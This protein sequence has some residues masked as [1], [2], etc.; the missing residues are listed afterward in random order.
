MA[1]KR[2]TKAQRTR[3]IYI[4]VAFVL[5]IAVIGITVLLVLLLGSSKTTI[6]LNE[7]THITLTGFNGEGVLS[8]SMDTDD[9]YTAFFETVDVEFSKSTNL[10]NGDEVTITY[11]YDKKV[12]KEYKIKVKVADMH[13]TVGNLVDAKPV[14]KNELFDGV[15][16]SFEGIAPMVEATLVT[17]KNEF[18]DIVSYEIIGGQQY[19][20]EGDT[21][22]VRAIFDEEELAEKDYV[23]EVT[24]EQCIKEYVVEDVD[25]YVTDI[26][27]ITDEM[28][29]SLKKEALSLFTDANEYG[30]RIFCDAGLVPVYIDKK[31]TFKW[32]SPNY[33]SSYLN[34]LKDESFG[35]TGTHVNDIK[36]CYE[37]VI[38]QADGKACKAEVVVRYEN[39]IVRADG[40]VDLNLES[41][42]IISAD[43]RD[44]HIKALVNNVIDDD[45]ES[46]KI[47]V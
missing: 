32:N 6:D 37:S 16:V 25:R 35:K 14:S 43:R 22:K 30:M 34:V 1:R 8:A 21:V 17:N 7:R 36:L 41:G 45:Y 10:T 39:I 18:S 9:A 24:S 40:T 28:M 33:I 27:E 42:D 15:D 38:S 11:T 46:E 4:R 20:D 26:D 2:M 19:Y 3:Q 44:S 31:T 23:A 13:Y 29:A 47:P 12:A 5:A